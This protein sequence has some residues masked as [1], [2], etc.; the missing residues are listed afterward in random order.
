MNS[1][2]DGPKTVELTERK[3]L[4]TEG[5]DAYFWALSA[6]QAYGLTGIQVVD[7]G[8]VGNRDL[9]IHLRA[10]RQATGF[11]PRVEVV[12]ILCDSEDDSKGR[13]QSVCSAL[14]DVGLPFPSEAFK[15][16]SGS[17]PPRTAVILFPG[18][19][20]D[21][22]LLPCGTLEDLC[23]SALEDRAL[24]DCVD[25]FLDCARGAGSQIRRPHKAKVHAFLSAHD[26]YVGMKIGEAA[27]A[28]AW[29]WN[30]PCLSPFRRI[31]ESL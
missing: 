12:G 2:T 5:K 16:S 28:G 8:G 10:L 20:P 17:V 14:D 27:R 26:K 7:F 15:V 18:L 25:S 13:L 3:L 1:S 19:S 11:T 4:L 23:L 21:G 22:A 29:D 6:L 24:L 30:H 9:R 31:L